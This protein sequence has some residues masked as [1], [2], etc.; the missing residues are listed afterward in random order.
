MPGEKTSILSLDLKISG[1]RA[2]RAKLKQ[3][4]FVV[5]QQQQQQQ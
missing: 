1:N 4:Q 3:Q 2:N 5:Q